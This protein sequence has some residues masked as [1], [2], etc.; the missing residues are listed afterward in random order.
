MEEEEDETMAAA[1]QLLEQV[2]RQEDEDPGLCSHASCS[3]SFP[4]H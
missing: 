2:Q 3:P 4:V 1:R